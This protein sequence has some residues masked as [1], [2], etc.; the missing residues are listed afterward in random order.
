MIVFEHIA[1]TLAIGLCLALALVLGAWAAWK[2]LPRN[3]G[4]VLLF[5]LYILT[6]LGVGW[7]LLL[8]GYKT[9]VTQL[10]KP[11]FIIALDTSQ[12][13]TLSPFPD[14]PTRWATA[15]AAL[16]RE[17]VKK[18]GAECEVEV[19]PFSSEVGENRPLPA[20][21]AL[22]PEGTATR[23][24]DTLKQIAD[25]SAGVNVAG[26]LLLSDGFDTREALDDW[27]GME[28]PF[29]IHTL[30]LEPPGGWQRE[31]DLKIEAVTTA[32]RVAVGWK[33]EFKVKV[34]GQGTRGAPVT[35]QIF[36]G[37]QLRYERPTQIPDEGGEREL[38]FEFE[39]PKIGTFNY[40][41]VVPPLPGEKNKD[42]NE[43]AVTIEVIDAPQRLLYVEGTPRWEFKFLKRALLAEQQV[44]PAIF[45][46]GADGVPQGG[47]AAGDVT[48]EMTPQQLAFFKIVMLGNLDAAEL[49]EE[50]ARNLVKFVENGG[51]LILL[52]G[53]K[54]W[55]PGGLVGTE[56]GKTLPVRGIAVETVESDTPYPVKLTGAALSH[57]AFAGDPELWQTIPPVLSVFSG[58]TLSPGAQAL[59]IAETPA[60]PQPMVV[61]QRYGQGKVAAILTDSLWR[62]QL[63]PEASKTKPYERFWTQLI[64][65][66]LPREEVLDRKRVELS[67]DRDQLYLGESIDLNARLAA[68]DMVNL[69]G[70]DA[71]I[72]LPDGREISYRMAPQQVTTPLGK[73]FP[74]YGLRFATEAAGSYKVLAS[75]RVKGNVLISEPFTFFVNPYSPETVPRPA[76]TELLQTISQTSGGQFFENLDALNDGLSSLKITATE[77]KS[78]EF[79]T[80]WREW[81][82]IVSLM[83]MLAISWG[84]RKFRNMP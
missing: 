13:M 36:S 21:A 29:P 10:L 75:A 61:T 74:G 52:G 47:T 65:W 60:G 7:C 11:R 79:R 54:A 82:A 69:E 8:L 83:G 37:D 24:R 48:A 70:V 19:I 56:L 62:W 73:T 53:T 33:S 49:G 2:Y 44:S 26:M 50:R 22:Q 1:S 6:L 72:T 63:G 76:R 18:I 81:P 80:L 38:V 51:S 3:R 46:T 28:R 5:A 4:N 77:E 64:S 78:A 14:T 15:Q 12:S 59:V 39:H 25:R 42:D 9:A 30:R 35:V 68:E 43:S 17:W 32:R 20:V 31:P 23:L 34:S 71:R 27:A 45:F 55:T 58:V 16:Q 67:A 84:V 57:P 41:V 66:L 40:R